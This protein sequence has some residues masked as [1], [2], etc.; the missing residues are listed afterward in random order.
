MFSKH[1][2]PLQLHYGKYSTTLNLNSTLKQY[3]YKVQKTHHH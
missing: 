3:Q 1:D 2:T